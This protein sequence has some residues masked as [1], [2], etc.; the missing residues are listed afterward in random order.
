[1]DF[2]RRADRERRLGDRRNAARADGDAQPRARR[3]LHLLDSRSAGDGARASGGPHGRWGGRERRAQGVSAMAVAGLV[4][5][6]VLGGPEAD[7]EDDEGQRS[8]WE[9][10]GWGAPADDE[11]PEPAEAPDAAETPEAA[12]A[13]E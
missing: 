9:A 11:A 2:G 13:P 4:L 3:H 5:L 8:A 10:A 12:D 1:R 6:A 7:G